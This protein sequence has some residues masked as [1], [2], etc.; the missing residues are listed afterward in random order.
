MLLAWFKKNIFKENSRGWRKIILLAINLFLFGLPFFWAKQNV[1]KIGGD[2]TRLYLYA[3]WEWLRNIS[4]YAWFTDMYSFGTYYPETSQIPFNIIAGLLKS[5]FFFLNHERIIYGLTIAL[6]FSGVYLLIVELINYKNNK[7]SFYAGLGGG[8]LYVFLPMLYTNFWPNPVSYFYLVAVLPLLLYFFIKALNIKKVYPL[9]LGAFTS[10]VFSISIMHPPIILPFLIC[11]AIFLILYFFLVEIDKWRFVKYLGLYLF[12]ILL[13]SSFY[14]IPFIHS[15]FAGNVMSDLALSL[16]SNE[17]MR[18]IISILAGYESLTTNMSLLFHAGMLNVFSGGPLA[19]AYDYIFRQSHSPLFLLF[20]IFL[21]IFFVKDKFSRTYKALVIASFVVLIS[22]FLLTV[23]IGDWGVSAMSWLMIHLPGFGVLRNFYYKTIVVYALFFSVSLGLAF[24]LFLEQTKNRVVRFAVV[25]II[26][27]F[28]GGFSLPFILGRH[29]NRAV[30]PASGEITY[31]VQLPSDYLELV[32]YLRQETGDNKILTLPLALGSWNM[33][34]SA[35]QKGVYIGSPILTSLA[36]KVEFSSFMGFLQPYYASLPNKIIVAIKN[37]DFV[38]LEKMLGILNIRYIEYNQDLID[39]HYQDLNKLKKSYLWYGEKE[40]EKE[41]IEGLL[42]TLATKERSFGQFHLYQTKDE[43]FLPHI[44]PSNDIVYLA[45][46]IDFFDQLVTLKNYKKSNIIVYEKNLSEANKN[47]IIGLAQKMFIIP[48]NYSKEIDDLYQKMYFVADPGTHEL[49]LS[50][51]RKLKEI[52]FLDKF[53]L[54][55]PK[56]GRYNILVS[57]DSRL[58]KDF[59]R[60]NLKVCFNDDCLAKKK[61]DAGNNYFYAGDLELEKRDY[62]INI[63][64]GEGLVKEIKAGDIILESGDLAQMEVVPKIEFKKISPVK[65]KVKIKNAKMPF[66]LVFNELYH[67][68]WK[69]FLDQESGVSYNDLYKDSEIQNSIQND[70]LPTEKFYETYWQNPILENDHYLVNTYA[71][72]WRIDPAEI[73][74]KNTDGSINLIIEFRGQRVAVLAGAISI[75][76]IIICVLY[77]IFRAFYISRKAK[78]KS[79]QE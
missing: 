79:K 1:Y 68:Q 48:Y 17:G 69:L 72:A 24:Y 36:G 11:S 5:I 62:K 6:A 3:P 44:Y 52:I 10:V 27:F 51:I 32:D 58:A 64:S 9:I 38:F 71:N 31:N 53:E 19:S 59:D 55:I 37:K 22:L 14:V 28:I 49:L 74:Q 29:F 12:L 4:S 8:L 73:N 13:L 63:Y 66:I 2:D 21:T 47:I 60:Q 61:E 33:V 70:G 16:H 41:K 75:L 57:K 34:T 39:S 46:D 65:Y 45:G 54:K 26:I 42:E 78:L 50:K 76:S 25:F 67:D 35:D 56:Q 7:N 18:N 30:N 77:L 15:F 43:N 23:N 20:F 40:E